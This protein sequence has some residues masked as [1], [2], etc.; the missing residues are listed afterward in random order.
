MAEV[1][2]GDRYKVLTPKTATTFGQGEP[3]SAYIMRISGQSLSLKH[4]SKFTVDEDIKDVSAE[5][6]GVMYVR[7]DVVELLLNESTPIIK[8]MRS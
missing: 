5:I 4:G 3:P 7:A 2:T 6:S 8:K 1:K